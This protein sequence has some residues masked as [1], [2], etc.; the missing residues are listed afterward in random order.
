MSFQEDHALETYRSMISISVEGFKTLLLINGGAIVA[1]LAY[2]GQSSK[3]TE[4]AKHMF[5]PLLFY[6]AGIVLTVLALMCSYATQFKL[7]NESVNPRQN[8]NPQHMRFV[9]AAIF[10][11]V[12]SLGSFVIGSFLSVRA[13]SKSSDMPSKMLQS[14]NCK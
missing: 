11:V 13:I 1:M 4:T 10:F 12:L 6:I 7:F 5:Y 14:P 2:L 8:N 3:G 9:Y